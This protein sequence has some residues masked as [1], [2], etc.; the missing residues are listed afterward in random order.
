MPHYRRNE[1]RD[2]LIQRHGATAGLPL[3]EQK[4]PE[5]VQVRIDQA[6]A[7]IPVADDT[8]QLGYIAAKMRLGEEQ[9]RVLDAL[10]MVHDGTNKEIAK[11]LGIDASTVSG[12]N[13]ELRKLGLIVFSQKRQCA[14]T[15][16]VVTAWKVNHVNP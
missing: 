1:Y 4:I 12:R 15:H 14:V 6:P 10:R 11:H 7:K 13:N 5:H 9:Q 8:R 3:F 16:N 2:E